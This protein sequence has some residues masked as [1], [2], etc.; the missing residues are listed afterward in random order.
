MRSIRILL[1][2]SGNK[3]YNRRLEFLPLETTMNK[4]VQWLLH[5]EK[6]KSKEIRFY[7]GYQPYGCCRVSD[8][9]AYTVFVR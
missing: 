3:D 7:F 5:A 1:P 6:T 8:R 2:L 4:N 9:V